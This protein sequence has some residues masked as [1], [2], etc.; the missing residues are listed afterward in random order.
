M[1]I[2]VVTSAMGPWACFPNGKKRSLKNSL[3]ENGGPQTVAGGF[4][5]S[6]T[7]LQLGRFVGFTWGYILFATPPHW[8]ETY[9]TR[10]WF[11]FQLCSIFFT[12]YLGK[13]SDSF[14]WIFQRGWFNH[15]T[16]ITITR[17]LFIQSS[18]VFH[19]LP[20]C[21]SRWR[22]H[23]SQVRWQQKHDCKLHHVIDPGRPP[24]EVKRARR[25]PYV[26]WLARNLPVETRRYVDREGF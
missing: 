3:K 5:P 17:F 25:S 20:C 11:R 19:G 23:H 24:P 22:K 4:I 21:E 1:L 16:T 13:D 12:P 6:H 7:L 26:S 10:W 18:W 8:V 9:I 14:F 15:Q 2:S